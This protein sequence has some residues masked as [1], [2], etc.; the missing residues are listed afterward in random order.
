MTSPMP[1]N[2]R[3]PCNCWTQVR[4][5][6]AQRASLEAVLPEWLEADPAAARA[7]FDAAS[8]TALDRERWEQRMD[9]LRLPREP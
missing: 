6:D 1:V 8:L 9:S 3:K 5:P 4:D 7:A 2:S